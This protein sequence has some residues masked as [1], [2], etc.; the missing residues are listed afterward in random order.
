MTEDEKKAY[1]DSPDFGRAVV[2]ARDAEIENR[3]NE[4][5]D[6]VLVNGY[7]KKIPDHSSYSRERTGC[8]SFENVL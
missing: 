4:Y 8:R 2:V 6:R 5:M 1:L 3:S 7:A